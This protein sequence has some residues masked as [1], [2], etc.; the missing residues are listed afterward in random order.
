MPTTPNY[1]N[2]AAGHV[3]AMLSIGTLREPA[4]PPAES[5]P[6]TFTVY[7]HYIGGSV[8]GPEWHAVRAAGARDAI[9][10]FRTDSGARHA[11]RMLE[12]GVCTIDRHAPIG[13]RIIPAGLPPLAPMHGTAGIGA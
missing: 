12:R 4:A 9:D 11:A 1:L 8:H 5:A 10:Y 6:P 7:R 3:A 2:A 13:C